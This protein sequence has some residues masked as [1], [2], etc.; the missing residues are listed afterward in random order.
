MIAPKTDGLLDQRFWRMI[1]ARLYI[2]PK[3]HMFSSINC[4]KLD[5]RLSINGVVENEK[6]CLL[7]R[8]CAISHTDSNH[9]F[10]QVACSQVAARI[11]A[12]IHAHRYTRIHVLR[13]RIRRARSV[14]TRVL[15]GAWTRVNCIFVFPLRSNTAAA[16][17]PLLPP[18]GPTSQQ[19]VP[20]PAGLIFRLAAQKSLHSASSWHIV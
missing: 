18:G 4:D 13:A 3:I 20:C 7:V 12:R 10:S 14:R 17:S 11:P 9:A 19:P 15:A 2:C 16:R 6:K 1:Y 5:L 8:F